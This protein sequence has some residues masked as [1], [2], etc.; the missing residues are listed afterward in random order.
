M[1]R[2]SSAVLISLLLTSFIR[3]QL[4]SPKAEGVYGGRINAM[5]VIKLSAT[6]SRV[7]IS[8]ESANS[9]FYVDNTTSGS[10]I[11][12]TFVVMPDV[13]NDDGY[14]SGI[15]KI[16]AHEASGYLFFIN[17]GSIFKASTAASSI[18]KL[19]DVSAGNATAL[20]VY[21]A[22]PSSYF[23]YIEGSDLH[24][25]T[26]DGSSNFSEDANSPRSIGAT[27]VSPVITVNPSNSY[28]Y[29]CDVNSTPVV[30]KSSDPYD[31]FGGSTS[32]SS[33][34]A[35]SLSADTWTAFDA[36]PDGTLFLGGSGSSVK[37]VAYSTDDG[38]TWNSGSTSITGTG[39]TNFGFGASSSPYTVYF[40]DVYAVYT[41]GSGF[42]SWSEMGNSGLE[43]HPND[44]SVAVDPNNTSV[45]YMT[46]D[47]GIGKSTDGGATISEMDDGVEAVQVQDF[48][49]NP[50]SDVAWA[51][52]KSGVRKVTDFTTGSGTWTNALFPTSDGSPY[53]SAEINSYTGDTAF[54]GN[55]RVYKTIDGG[56]N[57]T[58]VFT[59]E[60][61]R[62][63][64]L[65]I[66]SE[67]RAIEVD[68]NDSD[69]ILAGYTI[70]NSTDQGGVFYSTDG[71]G[72]WGQI[73]A[74]QDLPGRTLTYTTLL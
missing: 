30:Y 51:A 55:V 62:L 11:F 56:S 37:V 42:G 17:N 71:G 25:G 47:Q 1:K 18:F 27:P 38:S 8:T 73:F 54:A 46:T 12:G 14:G 49:L 29:V 74:G 10:T 16:S 63:Q 41:N 72:S 70:D 21:N 57:W 3:G 45:I 59:A 15:D 60:K 43:T 34:T 65:R 67:V 19:H 64:F 53:Y 26:L 48:S 24:F 28:V 9:V 40:A 39:G 66:N 32:F 13:G 31:S 36:G 69:M 6:K 35:T 61:I 50:S 4:S 44:G 68:P 2:L 22:S 52:S 7:F 33:L 58:Q 5:S 23:Y 20:L